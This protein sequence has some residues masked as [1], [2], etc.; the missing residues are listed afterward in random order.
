MSGML[1]KSIPTAVE[2]ASSPHLF[3]IFLEQIITDAMVDN[4]GMVSIMAEK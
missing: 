2:D 3:H 1:G 4:I